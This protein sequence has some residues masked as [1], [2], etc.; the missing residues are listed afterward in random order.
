MGRKIVDDR[1]V[2]GLL[3]P[4][5][6]ADLLGFSGHRNPSPGFPGNGEPQRGEGV[7][8]THY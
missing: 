3:L 6:V 2:G 8:V 5:G 7:G 1:L 4:V